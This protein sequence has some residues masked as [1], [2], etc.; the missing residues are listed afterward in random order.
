M[1]DSDKGIQ[2][3]LSSNRL[4]SGDGGVEICFSLEEE[5]GPNARNWSLNPRVPR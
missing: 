4:V 3:A 2:E 1:C 5:K